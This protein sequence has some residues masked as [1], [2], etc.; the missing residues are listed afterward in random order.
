M[1]AKVSDNI[2]GVDNQ[3]LA[4]VAGLLP[5]LPNIRAEPADRFAQAV[6]TLV[7][8]RARRAWPNEG[9]ADLAVFVM[10]DRPRQVGQDH[11]ARPFVDPLAQHDPVLGHLF[12]ANGD[13]SR[14][15][16]MSI[17]TK[18]NAILDWIDD[19]GLGSCPIVTVYRNSK[20]MVTR[21]AGTND[22]ARDDPIRD[23]E[24]TGTLSELK[25]AL[26]HFHERWL[27]TPA[28][29][30]KESGNRVARIGTFPVRTRNAASTTPWR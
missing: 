19:H 30:A 2:P 17:P 3:Q 20:Q 21:L 26:E 1:P 5:E 6:R 25:Q 7:E 28:C 22:F 14:G 29:C 18:P 13:A 8:K 10:V 24:P 16:F 11:G 9:D 27:F 23:E 12:F 4:A 15:H